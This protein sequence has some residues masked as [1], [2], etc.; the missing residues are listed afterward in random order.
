VEPIRIPNEHPTQYQSIP[1]GLQGYWWET[2]NLVCVPI[3]VAVNEG[4]GSFSTFLKEIESKGKIVFFP[5][6]ISKRLDTILRS[7]G[8]IDGYTTDEMFGYVDGLVKP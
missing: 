5:S 2:E 3:V 6:I 7:R 8:Y 4:D 1:P